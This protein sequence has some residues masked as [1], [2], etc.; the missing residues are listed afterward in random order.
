MQQTNLILEVQVHLTEVDERIIE[1]MRR[2][3]CD[4]VKWNLIVS[5]YS[6]MECLDSWNFPEEALIQVCPFYSGNNLSFFRILFS[7]IC[8][9]YLPFRL[10][11]K[12]Y[13]GIRH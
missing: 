5:E 10:I 8:R 3:S 9:I 11:G 1:S 4:T 2:Y 7:L 12:Q 13:S 6:D